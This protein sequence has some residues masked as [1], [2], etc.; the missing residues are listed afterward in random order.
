MATFE[1]PIASDAVRAPTFSD[2]AVGDPTSG[3]LHVERIDDEQQL[4]LI[5]EQWNALAGEIPFRS[6]EW[7]EAWWR[8]YRTEGDELCILTVRNAQQELVAL[9]PWYLSSSPI[10]GR[11]L[12]FLGSGDVCSDYLTVLTAA[13]FQQTAISAI[14]AWLRMEGQSLWDTIELQGVG[15]DDEAMALL[16]RQLAAANYRVDTRTNVNSWRIRFPENWEAYVSTLS[17]SRRE[18]VRQ[19]C[20]KKFETGHAR[21]RT[22]ECPEDLVEG[23]EVLRDLHQRRRQSLGDRGCFACPRFE[24]F[25]REVA[26]RFYHLSRLRLQWIELDG[27]PVAVEFDLAGGD[28][29]FYYQS[30]IEPELLDE[31]PGWLGTIGALR[32]AMWEGYRRFDFLRGDEDY[33]SHWRAEPYALI[34]IR[35]AA[36][37][38]SARTRLLVWQTERWARKHAKAVVGRE[39]YLVRQWKSLTHTTPAS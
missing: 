29:V 34:E 39:G 37:R 32:R 15:H 1:L 20:R 17:R 28:T 8:H 25:V 2:H 11:V 13:G 22:V 38:L 33:K 24:A 10:F 27:K 23:L 12:R 5:A 3:E 36:P 19:L 21:V 18:R 35:I 14:C 30:G 31:K 7:L 6:W 16:S 26:E 4:P 9:A